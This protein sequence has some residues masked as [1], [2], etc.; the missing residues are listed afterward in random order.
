MHY[1]NLLHRHFVWEN[2]TP[3]M[4]PRRK[5]WLGRYL[6]PAK[7]CT[8]VKIPNQFK[9]IKSI[10]NIKLEVR[11]VLIIKQQ[12]LDESLMHRDNGVAYAPNMIISP[13]QLPKTTRTYSK[14]PSLTWKCDWSH[15]ERQAIWGLGDPETQASWS[16]RQVTRGKEVKK[17]ELGSF[18]ARSN[19]ENPELSVCS[20][21]S[22]MLF[23]S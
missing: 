18:C 8:G 6:F 19:N 11:F 7:S 16:T 1:S 14:V 23:S 10:Q 20:T 5:M 4:V 22:L 12:V 2:L 13:K 9:H 17:R 3:I 15:Q 21:W